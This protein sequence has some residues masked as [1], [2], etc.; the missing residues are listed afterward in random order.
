VLSFKRDPRACGREREQRYF[1]QS[2]P[3]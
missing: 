1:L 3:Q 2:K